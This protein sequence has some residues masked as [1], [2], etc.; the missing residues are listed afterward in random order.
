V[1]QKIY[2]ALSQPAEGLPALRWALKFRARYVRLTRPVLTLMLLFALTTIYVVGI[3]TTVRGGLPLL[4]HHQIDNGLNTTSVLLRGEYHRLLTHSLVHLN[5]IHLFGN[6]LALW[7]LGRR[8]EPQFGLVR[9]ALLLAFSTAFAGILWVIFTG[10]RSMTSVGASTAV[11]GLMGAALVH[12]WL[13]RKVLGVE[14]KRHRNNLLMIIGFLFGTDIAANIAL[15]GAVQVD[16]AAHLYGMVGGGVIALLMAP[17]MIFQ[18]VGI[19]GA[20]AV[21]DVTDG[22]PLRWR[23]MGIL[24]VLVAVGLVVFE[25]MKRSRWPSV[26]G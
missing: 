12:I 17:R 4:L 25:F 1:R 14:F 13:N 8:L 7:L 2:Y 19:E 18:I 10:S 5:G 21:M 6:L 11:Y 9:Y 26:F 3:F 24:T 20:S 22:N 16:I 23:A 15:S